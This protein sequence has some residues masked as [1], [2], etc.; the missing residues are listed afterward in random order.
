MKKF[1]PYLLILLLFANAY[2]GK[3]DIR[4]IK[5]AYKRMMEAAHPTPDPN[6]I[7]KFPRVPRIQS[8]KFLPIF[9]NSNTIE[10]EAN[11]SYKMQNESSIAVNPTNPS[12][13]IASAVDYR[14]ESA[15][16]VYVSDDG[17]RTWKNVN[18][19]RPYAGWRSTNDPSVA[20][21]LDGTGYLCYGGFGK[22]DQTTD[23]LVGE[24]GVFISKTTDGGKTWKSHIPVIVH[25][26]AQTLDST[27]EDKYYV[28]VDNS[29]ISPYFG[30]LYIPWKRVTPRDSATQIVISKS[31]DKGE[32]WSSP[33]PI[34]PRKSGTSEDTTYGQSFPLAIT[35]PNGEVY[36][37]WNDGIEHGVGFAKSTDGGKSFSS[38]KIIFNYNIFGITKFIPGQGGYRHTVKGKVRAE[39][40]PVIACDLWSERKGYL[41]LTWAADS[42]PNIYFSRSTDG[43][44]TW[45][46]PVIIH[47][48]TKNDQFWQWIA[49]DPKSGDIAVMYFDSRDDESNIMV[50]CYVSYSR[51]GGLT[52][53]DRRVGDEDHDL[54]LNPFMDNAFA[55]DYSGV[56]FY[57]GIIYPS[58]V[59]MR[60]A[61]SNI[62]DSDVFTAIVNTRAP[63]PVEN[64]AISVFPDH[65]DRLKLSWDNP[66]TF[67]FGQPIKTSD[68]TLLLYRDGKFLEELKGGTKEYIDQNL[69][70]YKYYNY[71]VFVKSNGDTS[72]ARKA[73]G[74]PGGSRNPKPPIILSQKSYEQDGKITFE[75]NIL[76]PNK[77]EDGSTPLVDMD[78][79]FVYL[80]DKLTF[81]A[82]LAPSDSGTTKTIQSQ[83][84]DSQ[85]KGFYRV[86][87]KIKTQK[88]IESLPS[89]DPIF[90]FGDPINITAENRYFD[91]F[92]AK[93]PKKYWWGGK[94]NYTNEF[95]YSKPN[96]ITE[97]PNANY[98]ANSNDTLL[99]FPFTSEFP[100][101]IRFWNAAI[102]DPNDLAVLEYSTD[103]GKIWSNK[104]VNTE[105]SFNKSQNSFW[106]DGSLDERDWVM[107]ELILP[108]Y[109]GRVDLRFRFSSNNFRHDVGWFIDDLEYSTSQSNVDYEIQSI[110]RVYPTI[111]TQYI[112][113]ALG[114]AAD[115]ALFELFTIEGSLVMQT[116]LSSNLQSI[117]LSVLPKGIYFVVIRMGTSI[118]HQKI[119]LVD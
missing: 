67:T 101:S 80:D 49:V 58:W 96:S 111:T 25:T 62:R 48:T 64:F 33:I 20:F 4:K 88:G 24:N 46:S 56:A 2:S 90:Y 8:N 109:Q 76:M 63:L 89:N 113:V 93:T 71:S 44:N 41:Y 74:N 78:S 52:W 110:V 14:D 23:L 94:W 107:Q 29:T 31:T 13:L 45:S 32:T 37:V 70:D 47:E 27:F 61:V 21:A 39:T 91:D 68:Y 7:E 87:A 3:K 19:G 17:A 66:S 98:T 115:K 5:D 118:K 119:M 51:D 73:F 12:N 69:E 22:I 104:F 55:G 43:G 30:H 50:N 106:K 84:L 114:D 79:I 82:K 103:G 83:L 95:A 42:I 72:V 59:D 108:K 1:L 57:D 65:T 16:W 6:L 100:V 34:S 18:L 99:L 35:G 26:G 54:R 81:Q 105:A 28:H 112:N 85:P 9:L 11:E 75:L 117:D 86:T 53:I 77:R 15:T 38:P 97:S 102:I 116:D 60:N 36:C 92:D 10:D 40:Y